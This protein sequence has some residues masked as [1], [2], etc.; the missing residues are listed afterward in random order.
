MKPKFTE[1]IYTNKELYEHMQGW[2]VG[3]II[4][5]L[6]SQGMWFQAN[7]VHIE[8]LRYS[9]KIAKEILTNKTK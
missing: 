6:V 7:K 8:E 9:K 3:N 1:E 4:G 5:H 2:S